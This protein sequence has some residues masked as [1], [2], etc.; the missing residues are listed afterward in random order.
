MP[1]G[2]AV[3][4]PSRDGTLEQSTASEHA[5]YRLC[6]NA[7]NGWTLKSLACLQPVFLFLF[8]RLIFILYV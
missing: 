8:L 5:S 6:V 2:S 7:G 3:S 1:S 4:L